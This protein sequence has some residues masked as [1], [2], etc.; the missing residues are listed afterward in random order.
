VQRPRPKSTLAPAPGRQRHWVD[1]GEV[2]LFGYH[3][4]EV[5][6]FQRVEVGEEEQEG[7]GQG[8]YHSGKTS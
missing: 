5:L 7:T 4:G 6:G 1:V 3:G 8:G 2:C